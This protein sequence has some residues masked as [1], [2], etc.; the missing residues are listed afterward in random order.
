MDRTGTFAAWL[1]LMVLGLGA[2]L[3][4]PAGGKGPPEYGADTLSLERLQGSMQGQSG[5]VVD[6]TRDGR[7]DLVVGAPYASHKGTGG[8]ILV[9]A[10]TQAGGFAAHP[11]ALVEGEGNLGWSLAPLGPGSFAAGA[12]SGSGDKASLAGTVAIYRAKHGKVV[13]RALLEGER[14]LDK[15]GYALVSGDFNGDGAKDLA[16]GA[17][18][19]SPSAALYQRGAVYVYFGPDFSQEAGR[20]VRIPASSANGGIGFSLATG[21]VDA[22]GFDD[23]LMQA[24]GKVIVYRGKNGFAP[25]QDNPDLVYKS[26][27][28]TTDTNFG[29]SIAV[30]WKVDGK[31]CNDV[32]IGASQAV[33]STENAIDSG[34]I[35][36]FEG[37]PS[38]AADPVL[39]RIDGEA[40]CGHISGRFGH[41]ILPLPDVSGDGVPD[42]AVSALHADGRPSCPMTGR[43]FIFDGSKLMGSG[44][45]PSESLVVSDIPGSAKD[46]HFG[47]FLAPLDGGAR[48]AAGCPTEKANTGSVR[49]IRLRRTCSDSAQGWRGAPL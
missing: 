5:I 26:P 43:I 29:Q 24:T 19:H 16:V 11:S 42:L 25:T 21:D 45:V 6:V 14:A 13:Q 33:G 30:L 48:L 2:C 23:L 1:W 46:M 17:P 15:F 38:Q 40:V 28:A 10:G 31:G 22:D 18:F 27:S 12:F 8:A 39:A 3:P 7:E 9:Y 32:A 44:S 49:L 37:C 36:V 47:A 41:A 4:P 20:Y 34:R 35:Y